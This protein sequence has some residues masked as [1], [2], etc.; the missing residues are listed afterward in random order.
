[1]C[2]LKTNEQTPM[3][4]SQLYWLVMKLVE[5]LHVAKDNVFLVDNTR[6]NLLHTAGHLPQVRLHKQTQRSGIKQ[7]PRNLTV[8]K[9]F[10][11]RA[12]NRRILFRNE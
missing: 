10:D 7:I 2:N 12:S 11:V 1:M 8:K 4:R 6:R 5:V 9:S 3:I